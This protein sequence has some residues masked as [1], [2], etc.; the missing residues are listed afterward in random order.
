[1]RV[2]RLTSF[3]RLIAGLV[4]VLG[5]VACGCTK[6]DGISDVDRIIMDQKK[7]LI[8]LSL[9]VGRPSERVARWATPGMST[10]AG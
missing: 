10:S 3:Q 9:R 5:F 4:L 7:G 8:R 1:M 6:Y 2:S